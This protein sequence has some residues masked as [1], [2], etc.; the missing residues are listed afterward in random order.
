MYKKKVLS[1]EHKRK[2]SEITKRRWAEGAFDS[3]EMREKWRATA[4][5][6]IAKQGRTSTLMYTPSQEMLDD[7][8]K[9][10]DKELAEKWHV[11]MKLLVDL[12]KRHGIKSFKNRHGLIPHKVE[13]G[14]EYKWCGSGHW[15]NVDNFGRHS[16]RY[17]GLRGHCKEH[18]NESSRRAKQKEYS[19]PEGKSKV[20]FYNNRRKTALTLWEHQDEIR[21]FELYDNRCGYCGTPVTPYTVEYDHLLPVSRGGKTI[22]SNM[23]PSCSKCNRGVGGKYARL[24]ED[25]IVEKFGY[26]I[27]NT[28]LMKIY[29]KQSIIAEETRERLEQAINF[30]I[31]EN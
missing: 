20:R 10:G 19:T 2:M 5:S 12:R 9:L 29:E 16:S 25:W 28:I 6:G 27:G 23:I 3:P 4:L 8:T 31:G 21:A 24:V 17:D 26:E 15:E 22:P 1:E 7:F 18:S 11:S 14:I 13:D 30:P